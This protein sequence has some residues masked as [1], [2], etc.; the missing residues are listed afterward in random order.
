MGGQ[1]PHDWGRDSRPK[2]QPAWLEAAEG[3]LTCRKCGV[4]KSIAGDVNADHAGFDSHD[5]QRLK[6]KDVAQ[7][8]SYIDAKGRTFQ[9]MQELGC[10]MFILDEMGAIRENRQ[11]VR[12]VD[13]RVDYVDDRVDDQ[14]HRTDTIEDR[15]I[16]LERQNAKLA[17]PIDVTAMVEWLAEMVAVS[18]AQELDTVEVQIEGRRVA[19]LPP[20]VADLIIDVGSLRTPERISVLKGGAQETGPQRSSS[21]RRR[22]EDE[23]GPEED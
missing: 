18:A 13:D 21:S 19:A 10:P 2:G 23:D 4:E 5:K 20:P 1:D 7:I 11:M 9:T 14:E 6:G 12:Q 8:H 17:Q 22:L 15:V 16:E 3:R